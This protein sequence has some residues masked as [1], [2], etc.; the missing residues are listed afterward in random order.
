[1]NENRLLFHKGCLQFHMNNNIFNVSLDYLCINDSTYH[2]YLYKKP[3]HNNCF[4]E[5]KWC[6]YENLYTMKI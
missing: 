5:N 2:L 3:I 1:M 4:T 6:Y